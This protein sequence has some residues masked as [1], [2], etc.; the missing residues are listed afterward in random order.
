M[1]QIKHSYEKN[2]IIFPNVFPQHVESANEVVSFEEAVTHL[3]VFLIYD[4]TS[5]VHAQGPVLWWGD[6]RLFKKVRLALELVLAKMTCMCIVHLG[7]H[8]VLEL[9]LSKKNLC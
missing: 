8:D 6:V 5:K 1:F 7:F 3:I 4:P 9:A 2:N